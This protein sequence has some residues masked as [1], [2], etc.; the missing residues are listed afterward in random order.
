MQTIIGDPF[1]PDEEVHEAGERWIGRTTLFNLW[2]AAVLINSLYSFWWDVTND[3]GLSLLTPSG[4]SASPAVSYAFIHPP[5]GSTHHYHHHH[6]HHHPSSSNSNS[7]ARLASRNSSLSGGPSHHRVRSLAVQAPPQQQPEDESPQHLST[8]YPP[9]PSRPHSPMPIPK[10]IPA[11]VPS[12]R[13]TPRGPGHGHTRAFS[14]ATSPNLSFPF[15]RPILLLPDPSIYYLCI[16]LDLILRL[17]WSLK[18]SSHLHSAQEVEAG[19]FLVELLEVVRR[20]IW[21]YL[22]IE[23]EAVRKGAGSEVVA[24]D[25]API[26][27]TVAGSSNGSGAVSWSEKGDS[28]ARLRAQE[29]YELAALRNS[30]SGGNSKEGGGGGNGWPTPDLI[31]VAPIVDIPSRV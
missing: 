12:A 8:L 24:G 5:A 16:L 17:T 3:W 31:Q 18:L 30:S 1:D 14:T 6:H 21:V 26:V 15:L 11:A 9:P 7:N 20:W 19:V 22:R 2:I 25:E 10:P 27:A 13:I 28:E 4:W 29:E 23:W